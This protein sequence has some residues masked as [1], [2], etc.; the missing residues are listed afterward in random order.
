MCVD[1]GSNELSGRKNVFGAEILC[2]GPPKHSPGE[3]DLCGRSTRTF[4]RSGQT[5]P[6]IGTHAPG[7]HK[8]W[9]C[10]PAQRPRAAAQTLP[11][12]SSKLVA[13]SPNLGSACLFVWPHHHP[14]VIQ[15]CQHVHTCDQGHGGPGS[16][17][18][19]LG[20]HTWSAGV[21][22]HGQVGIGLSLGRRGHSRSRARP[23]IM[24]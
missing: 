10:W 14:Q 18:L 19:G 7:L 5:F 17:S 1:M 16:A 3:R 15:V 21:C 8:P 9:V 6:G 24:W 4:S 12:V 13:E 2:V 11:L 22:Y 23:L 20:R